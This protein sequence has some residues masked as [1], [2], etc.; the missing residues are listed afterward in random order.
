MVCIIPVIFDSPLISYL[1]VFE[2]ASLNGPVSTS[3]NGIGIGRGCPGLI[4]WWPVMA[5]FLKINK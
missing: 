2:C 1:F 4:T 3:E 5:S